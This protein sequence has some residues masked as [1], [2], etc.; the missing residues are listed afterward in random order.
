MIKLQKPLISDAEI[1]TEI[2]KEAY[3]PNII[4]KIIYHNFLKSE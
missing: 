3:N 2:K 4:E 1:I